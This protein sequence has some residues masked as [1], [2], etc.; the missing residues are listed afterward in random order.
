MNPQAA[1]SY[2]PHFSRRAA[3]QALGVSFLTLGS[4]AFAQ[5]AT[6]AAAPAD[7]W[8]AMSRVGYGPNAELVRAVQA[9]PSPRAWALEQLD[10]AWVTSQ[11]PPRIA[12]DG[13]DF[14]APLPRIFEPKFPI[15]PNV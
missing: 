15:S 5:S 2:V 3:L 9:A 1:L 10:L 7:A 6:P 4:P 11:S 8:R 13:A 14:N 12:A